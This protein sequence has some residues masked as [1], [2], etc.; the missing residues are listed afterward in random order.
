[1]AGSAEHL[2]LP[3]NTIDVAHARFAYFFGPGSRAGLDEVSR[4]LAPEGV[5]LVV[6]NSW[7]GGDFAKL[8]RH[9]TVGNAA[10]DPAEVETWW[11]DQGAIRHEVVGGWKAT[12]LLELSRILHLEFPAEVADAFLE[13]HTSADL[14]YHFNIFQWRPEPK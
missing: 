3:D 9:S 4:V 6:D 13:G 5:L 1:M 12:S 14:S 11:A 8:L 10:V 2:P 7:R